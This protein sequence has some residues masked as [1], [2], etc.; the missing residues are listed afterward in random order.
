MQSLQSCGP[1]V[2]PLDL[3]RRKSWAGKREDEL[4]FLNKKPLVLLDNPKC[5]P[6]K[7]PERTH[8]YRTLVRLDL[9]REPAHAIR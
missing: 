2:L 9:T 4:V 1:R 5:E 7:L 6:P 8:G 3:L